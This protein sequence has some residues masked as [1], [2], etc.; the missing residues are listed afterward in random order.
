MSCPTD[1]HLR[2]H[3]DEPD[4]ATAAHVADCARCRRQADLARDDARFAAAAIGG[5]DDVEPARV[6]VDAAHRAVT[7]SWSSAQHG[8]RWRLPGAVAAAAV[9]LLVVALVGLTPTGRQA[10]ADFLASFRAERFEVVTFD[11]DQPLGDTEGLADI[12]EVEGDGARDP[13]AVDTLDAAAETAGFAP[14]APT[15]LPAGATLTGIEAQGPA[16]VRLTLHAGRAP[17]LPRELAGAQVVVSLPGMVAMTYESDDGMLVVGE[18]G[19]LAVDARGA[20]LADIRTYLLGRP[21]IPPD[22]AEQLRAIDDWTTTIPLP[23]PVDDLAWQETT[24]GDAAGLALSDPLGAGLLWQD[25]GR[26]H[27]VG[28]EGFDI[29]ALRDIADGIR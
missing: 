23:V 7:A 14:S 27:A 26:I 24:V 20:D 21:E 10:A 3:L 6:D 13:R 12:F 8:R 2:A 18:A 15:T 25:D 19:Q 5:L 17:D 4:A 1:A 29:D 16:T 9:G 11:P 28:G 22:V